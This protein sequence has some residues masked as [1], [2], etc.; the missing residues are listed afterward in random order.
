M[1][2]EQVGNAQ[3]AP[4]SINTQSIEDDIMS[5]NFFADLDRSVNGG[6]LD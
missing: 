5:D 3:E 2:Q 6:I 4:E 1:S